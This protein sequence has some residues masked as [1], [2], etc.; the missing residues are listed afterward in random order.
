MAELRLAPGFHEAIRARLETPEGKAAME[1]LVALIAER[2][3]KI[4]P[5]EF[6]DT[7]DTPDGRKKL[8]ELWPVIVDAYFHG[9]R[10]PKSSK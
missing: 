4:L 2:T 9:L 6:L 8:E 1:R 7:L 3:V 10:N 5:P